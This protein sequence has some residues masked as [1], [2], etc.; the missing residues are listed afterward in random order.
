MKTNSRA[1]EKLRSREAEPGSQ[2]VGSRRFVTL[3]L[4][5][6]DFSTRILTSDPGMSLKTKE[7]CGKLRCGTI[8]LSQSCLISRSPDHRISDRAGHNGPPSEVASV[9]NATLSSPAPRPPKVC[10]AGL[11][12]LINLGGCEMSLKA[13]AGCCGSALRLRADE[14]GSSPE[15]VKGDRLARELQFIFGYWKPQ[16]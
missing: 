5:T 11:R 15:S 8:V 10:S 13:R 14:A 1:V 4:S 2:A 16:V 6:L 3:R 9:S 7:G 12:G